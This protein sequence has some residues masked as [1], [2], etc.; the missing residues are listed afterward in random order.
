MRMSWEFML[1]LVHL[2]F[3]VMAVALVRR[4]PCWMQ[5]WVMSLLVIAMALVALGYLGRADLAWW[6]QYAFLAGLGIGHCANLILLWRLTFQGQAWKPSS[7]PSLSSP[8][9]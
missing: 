8:A 9:R 7:T 3:V 5:R 4:T 1:F 2:P 6:G